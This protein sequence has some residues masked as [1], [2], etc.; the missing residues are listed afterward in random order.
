[1][2]LGQLG[3]R[4]WRQEEGRAAEETEPSVEKAE[5]KTRRKNWGTG[6]MEYVSRFQH[7]SIDTCVIATAFVQ[8]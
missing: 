7:F 2:L 4:W 1:M 8:K 6:G 5:I 3:R